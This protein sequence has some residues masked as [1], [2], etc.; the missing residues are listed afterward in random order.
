VAVRGLGRA[1]LKVWCYQVQRP[2]LFADI[3]YGQRCQ[4]V[5]RLVHTLVVWTTSPGKA[6]KSKTKRS[7]PG[8]I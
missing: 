2:E 3:I 5:V 4:F 7:R 1:V 6:I 8:Q